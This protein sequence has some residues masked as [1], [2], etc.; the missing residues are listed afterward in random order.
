MLRIFD[1]IFDQFV[2]VYAWI[3][4]LIIETEIKYNRF[5]HY[6]IVIFTGIYLVVAFMTSLTGTII[7]FVLIMK[8]F[9]YCIEMLV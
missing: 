7:F 9:I 6:V 2:N 4:T 5:W 1:F 3:L 8:F